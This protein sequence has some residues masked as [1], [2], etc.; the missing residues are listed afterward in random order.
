ME[1]RSS[2]IVELAKS[3]ISFKS[4]SDNILELCRIM[5]FTEDYF[6]NSK[7]IIER[8]SISKKPS[9]V[10]LMEKTKKPELMLNAHL[11]VVPAA[12]KD[13]NAFVEGGKLYGRGAI[14]D[15]LPAAVLVYLMKEFS[16]KSKKPSMGLM[17]TADEETGGEN[18]VKKLLEEYSCGFAIIPDGGNMEII[19][20]MK[21]ILQVRIKAK[22][23]AAH[24]SQPWLGENAIEKLMKAYFEIKK[25]FPE[26][27]PKN[28]WMATINPA[29]IKAGD[30]INRV[31][32][33]AEIYIDIRHPETENKEEILKKIK[34]IK[35]IE[36]DVLTTANHMLADKNNKYIL[37]LKK[38]AER[39][40]NK[41]T[42]FGEE[43]G[44]SDARY[45]S[46]KKIPAA[47]FRIKGKNEH[48]DN[49]YAELKDLG[50]F[51]QIL[52]EFIDK[53]IRNV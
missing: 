46:E 31:P 50:K 43:H 22:G 51:Y 34:S 44:A 29:V 53:S 49:E 48:A 41:K 14:D 18:G 1:Q 5:D 19:T 20:R 32:D 16:K 39:I 23:K 47:V 35:G 21:G 27:T 33:Y 3:L 13:F 25:L 8:H 4:T 15:K 30:A 10:I 26:T 45:F 42:E 17:L 2:E 12:E 28:R 52:Y 11:D 36:V 6:K 9:M 7:V 40:T 24:G 37:E 38:T